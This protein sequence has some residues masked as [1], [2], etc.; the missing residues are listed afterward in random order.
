M[1]VVAACMAACTSPREMDECGGDDCCK[2]L[3]GQRLKIGQSSQTSLSTPPNHQLRT[4]V[5]PP[6]LQVSA[7]EG[8]TVGFTPHIFSRHRGSAQN[9]LPDTDTRPSPSPLP[10]PHPPIHPPR[11][12]PEA[13]RPLR[14]R[15]RL[16]PVR[17]PHAGQR[18]GPPRRLVKMEDS[19]I[20]P[21]RLPLNEE[22]REEPPLCPAPWTLS[23]RRRVFPSLISSEVDC[24]N[25]WN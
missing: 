13:S 9:L 23:R 19:G 10:P 20:W 14:S 12:D 2:T 16:S 7:P 6:A 24:S 17:A 1:L 11:E 8:G 4:A 25:C 5:D 18:P 21:K 15:C 22:G 3:H